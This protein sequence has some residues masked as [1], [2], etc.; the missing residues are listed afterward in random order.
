M[1]LVFTQEGVSMLSGILQSA[2][3]VD[4]HIAIMRAFVRLR[5][6][7]SANIELA[8]KLAELERKIK[9]HDKSIRNLFETIQELMAP[10]APPDSPRPVIGFKPDS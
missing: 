5:Q 3:A 2:C 1:P 6:M 10:S 4:V 8:A 7:V 9:S